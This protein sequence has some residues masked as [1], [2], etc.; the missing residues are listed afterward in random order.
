MAD[1]TIDINLKG[2]K[3]AMTE[4]QKK[5]RQERLEKRKR[6]IAAKKKEREERKKAKGRQKA[7]ATGIGS[8]GSPASAISGLVGNIAGIIPHAALITLSISVFKQ[9]RDQLFAPGGPFDTRLRIEVEKQLNGARARQVAREL[10]VG[11][12]F[13]FVSASPGIAGRE[14]FIG[15]NFYELAQGR[16]IEIDLATQYA[17]KGF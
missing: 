17:A 3:K 12:R 8:A 1:I 9:I 13:L 2:G 10:A 16:Q 6:D 14:G 7:V 5:A 4:E 11:K 15:G